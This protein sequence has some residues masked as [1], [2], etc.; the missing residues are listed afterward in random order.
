M[1]VSLSSRVAVLIVSFDAVDELGDCLAASLLVL[2]EVRVWP[3]LS[4]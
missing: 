1:S 2:G 4:R 3:V